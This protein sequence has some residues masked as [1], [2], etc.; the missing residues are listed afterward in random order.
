[1]IK[2]RTSL[3]IFAIA[4]FSAACSD[5]TAPSADTDV[6]ADAQDSS[7]DLI[8]DADDTSAEDT[9]RG[10]VVPAASHSAPCSAHA[11]CDGR[12][13]LTENML[14]WF[15]GG[16]CTMFDCD[17]DDPSSCGPDGMCLSIFGGF[18]TICV[19]RCES[20]SECR[21]THNCAGFCI[22]E[23][24]ASEPELPDAL[25]PNDSSI[26]ALVEGIDEDRMRDR[27][28][29]LSGEEPWSSPEGPQTIVSR[30]VAHPD[31]DVAAD[32]LESLLDGMGYEVQRHIGDQN[33]IH[34]ENLVAQLDGSD[35]DLDPVY[36][37]AHYD[38]TISFE[39]AWSASTDPA[40]GASDNGS[41]VVVLLELAQIF[42]ERAETDPPPRTVVFVLFDAEELGLVGSD[43][44][45]RELAEDG[46]ELACAFNM[47]MFAWDVEATAGRFWLSFDEGDEAIVALG[48]E[49][50][51]DF[52]PEAKP[53]P[54]AFE[55]WVMSDHASFWEQGYCAAA[56]STFPP[57]PA[58][59]TYD[60]KL[61][62][63]D[64]EFFVGISRSAAAVVAA[65]AYHYQPED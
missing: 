12:V 63:Y 33:E 18:P 25:E 39:E 27:L 9:S 50:V 37:T 3:L 51:A 61:S 49:A 35:S 11:Q 32:Y 47:D 7:E 4:P 46:E 60:D 2:L 52:V 48:L 5:D 34:Y 62:T 24:I 40:P 6:E 41:G 57:D 56:I 42:A 16:Y 15:D 26:L 58:Y 13:C 17:L 59:H 22:P 29:V 31:H 55:L 64:W 23:S 10:D 45:T 28:E 38:S 36:V 43:H 44:F 19:R 53:I 14:Q 21:D 20:N 65:W 1:M 8:L 30:A 54:S